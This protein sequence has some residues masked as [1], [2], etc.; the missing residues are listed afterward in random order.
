MVPFVGA[1]QLHSE[2]KVSTMTMSMANGIGGATQDARI[3]PC[4]MRLVVACWYLLVSSNALF[5]GTRGLSPLSVSV[6][7]SDTVCGQRGCCCGPSC[8][9]CCGRSVSLGVNVLKHVHK[10]K[11]EPQPQG[12]RLITTLECSDGKPRAYLPVGVKLLASFADL[13]GYF[14]LMRARYTRVEDSRRLPQFSPL[15][16]SKVP[17]WI[18]GVSI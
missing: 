11:S 5:L 13:P 7:S 9:G 16:P 17:I 15:P 14:P 18:P 12:I 8:S 4:V 2:L 6:E 1:G 10:Q 3:G